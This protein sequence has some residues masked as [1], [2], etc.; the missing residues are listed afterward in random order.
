MTDLTLKD[1]DKIEALV[2]GI[3][4]KFEHEY[5]PEASPGLMRAFEKTYGFLDGYRERLK[6]HEEWVQTMR[7]FVDMGCPLFKEERKEK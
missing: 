7:S 1:L 4:E 2:R 6:H 3:Q 5:D